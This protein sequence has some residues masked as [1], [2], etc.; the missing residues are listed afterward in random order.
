MENHF[1]KINRMQPEEPQDYDDDDER[2]EPDYYVCNC[3]QY[4]CVEYHGNWGCPKCTA[5]MEE[6]YY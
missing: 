1:K 5:I 3:C 4:S 6:A 2:D